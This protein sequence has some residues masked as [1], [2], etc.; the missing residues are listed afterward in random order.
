MV[1]LKLLG[2]LP[3]AGLDSGSP[4]RPA[5]VQG[6]VDTDNLSYRPEPRICVGSFREADTENVAE[7]MFQGGVIGLR[8]CHRRLEQHPAID[9]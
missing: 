1:A 6:R 2:Q 9:G 4:R 5:P 8:R 7:M 3:A